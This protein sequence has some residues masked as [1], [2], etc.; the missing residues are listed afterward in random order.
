MNFL[1]E[2]NLRNPILARFGW[3]NLALFGIL[4]VLSFIDP[5][6]ITGVN[7]WVK[8]LKFALSI[9]LFVWTM[10][11]LL[12]YLPEV[13]LARAL[14]WGIVI[15]LAVEQVCIVGQAARG[16]TSHFNVSSTFNAAVFTTMGVFITINT[17]LVAV[18]AVA[19]FAKPFPALPPAYLWGIRLGL[20]LFVLFSFEGMHMAGVLQRHT[21]GA[22]DGG[23]GLPFLN[24]S[25]RHGDLRVAH[26]V[27]LHAL[28][29]LPLFGYFVAQAS[30]QSIAFGLAYGAGAFG[31]YL[32]A[33]ADKPVFGGLWP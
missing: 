7:A 21:V 24:W 22:P 25:T 28:Q 4:L 14:S 12:A 15:C 16:V 30:W 20:V 19:F 5:R 26:F 18:A 9:A 32:R 10:G 31:L 17:I 2:L 23:P 6:Q 33:L 3:L 1:H 13:R 11:W 8:P 29:V 27:G